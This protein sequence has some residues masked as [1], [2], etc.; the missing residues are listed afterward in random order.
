MGI[1]NL[2]LFLRPYMKKINMNELKNK[3]IGIDGYVW[4]HKGI[5]SDKMDIVDNINSNNYINY[6]IKNIKILKK[7]YIYPI[8]VF[9]GR[10]LCIKHK[11]VIYRQ[12]RREEQEKKAMIYKKKDYLKYKK[13]MINTIKVGHEMTK[14]VIKKLDELNIEYI[15]SPHESDAQLSYLDK[16]GY[17]DY[18]I[19]EDSDLIAYGCKKI[20][21]K[22]DSINETFMLIKLN[23]I[24]R[25][26]NYDYNKLLEFCI[27][28]GCDYFKMKGVG[29]KTSYNYFQKQSNFKSSDYMINMNFY[30]AK[31]TFI[32]QAVYDPIYKIYKYTNNYEYFKINDQNINISN[33]HT[34]T[35]QYFINLIN[36]SP[37]LKCKIA[38]ILDS[39]F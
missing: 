17:I 15:I 35:E 36:Q 25:L 24:F 8:F 4:I 20:L 13:I 6:I 28:S 12:I 16:I 38:G 9:D 37:I 1:K 23:D 29:I 22:Y 32:H 39:P 34:K 7:Y 31:Y 2:L 33:L 11:E 30:F 18:V 5:F 21:Y 27:L 26:F 10:K 19:T 3:R 14:K